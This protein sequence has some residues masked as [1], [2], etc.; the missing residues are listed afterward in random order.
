MVVITIGIT[1]WE[2]NKKCR[3]CGS[4]NFY[5][6]TKETVNYKCLSCRQ[7]WV[8]VDGRDTNPEEVTRENI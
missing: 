6:P 3:R 1:E 8:V 2:P 5:L 7:E 4:P